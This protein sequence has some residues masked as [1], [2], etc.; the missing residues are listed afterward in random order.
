ML[1]RRWCASPTWG[2]NSVIRRQT[3]DDCGGRLCADLFCRRSLFIGWLIAAVGGAPRPEVPSC[4]PP[5]FIRP[6]QKSND[7]FGWKQL[8][9]R[10][11]KITLK[12]EWVRW[13]VSVLAT[14][15]Q[16]FTLVVVVWEFVGNSVSGKKNT[17]KKLCILAVKIINRV[18]SLFI[19]PAQKTQCCRVAIVNIHQR[20]AN[21]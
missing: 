13:R 16:S 4:L 7:C 18:F 1:L 5:S 17:Q 11:K 6:P 14:A 10:N 12:K 3:A 8:K 9:H 21:I 2:E 20:Q 19:F 15:M